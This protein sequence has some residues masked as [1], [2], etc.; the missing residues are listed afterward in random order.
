[1]KSPFPADIILFMDKEFF[2]IVIALGAFLIILLFILLIHAL[3]SKKKANSSEFINQ[4]ASIEASARQMEEISR[5]ISSLK[6][7]LHAPKLR[8][9]FGEELLYELLQDTLPSKNFALQYRFSD[10]AT[11]DA[12]IKLGK[13]IVPIDSKFPLESFERY[14]AAPEKS[15]KNKAKSEFNRSL[16]D[17]IDEISQKYIR[18]R[19]GSFDFAMMYIPSESIYYELLRDKSVMEEG[20]VSLYDEILTNDTQKGYEL[21]DY[22]MKSH[23]IPVSPN[24]FY[25]YL[26]AIVY[27]LKG[28]K[29]ED[30]ALEIV[31]K[32]SALEQDFKDFLTDMSTLGKHINNACEKFKESEDKARK[33]SLQLN[34][35]IKD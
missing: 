5:E 22:A 16:K 2:Y 17:R 7:I 32:I 23:V 26:M 8:G 10:G 31:R 6:S 15:S 33:L 1:M 25:A 27:G 24:T 34:N 12:V 4:I 18:P 14:L 28:L 11:V 19:E 3:L 35:F 29:I 30:K 20:K 9:N 13:N 21:F